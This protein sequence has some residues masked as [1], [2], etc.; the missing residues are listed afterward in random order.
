MLGHQQPINTPHLTAAQPTTTTPSRSRSP[1][2]YQQHATTD[3]C[4][5]PLEEPSMVVQM[6]QL[7]TTQSDQ[8]TP[9]PLQGQSNTAQEEGKPPPQVHLDGDMGKK[10]KLGKLDQKTLP[11]WGLMQSVTNTSGLLQT[12]F[13]LGKSPPWSWPLNSLNSHWASSF[14]RTG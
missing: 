7:D 13:W 10:H 5:A 1:T 8:Q 4:W 11:S 2:R 9:P 6:T 12:S 3:L 14:A